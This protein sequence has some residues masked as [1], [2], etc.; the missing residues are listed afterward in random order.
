MMDAPFRRLGEA[1]IPTLQ[2]LLERCEE[3]YVLAEG[4]PALP[5]EAARELAVVPPGRSAD[6]LFVLGIDGDER[7]RGVLSIL[8]NYPKDGEWWIA[9]LLLDPAHRS[10]GLGG[11]AVD[12]V[13]AW[14]AA[15][16]ATTLYLSVLEQNPGAIRFWRRLGFEDVNWSDWTANSG[17]VSRVLIMKRAV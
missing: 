9:L 3:F 5:D 15:Q 12:A 1:D 13:R 2:A 11:A 8:R 16:G 10:R 7:L 4:C 14:I 17:R 6:D